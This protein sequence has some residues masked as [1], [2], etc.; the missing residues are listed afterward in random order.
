MGAHVPIPTDAEGR[1]Q[2][3]GRRSSKKLAD[4]KTDR[5]MRQ[6]IRDRHKLDL[7]GM[8]IQA[9]NERVAYAMSSGPGWG[10]L[11][12]ARRAPVLCVVPWDGT[13]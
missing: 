3:A 5:Y 2:P 10:I 13:I 4:S 9:F 1:K 6:L 11:P 7:R 8:G 12:Q